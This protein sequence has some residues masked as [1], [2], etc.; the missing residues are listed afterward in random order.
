MLH[1]STN[2]IVQRVEEKRKQLAKL[3]PWPKTYLKRLH[4]DTLENWVTGNIGLAFSNFKKKHLKDNL[5]LANHNNI[6]ALIQ[7]QQSIAEK[8]ITQEIKAVEELLK[9]IYPQAL[10]NK[11]NLLLLPT[12]MQYHNNALV[13]IAHQ[14]VTVNDLVP[15]NAQAQIAARAL[16]NLQLWQQGYGYILYN[17]ND[18]LKW[19]Q[20]IN[21]AQ[22][23]NYN[24]LVKLICQ[25]VEIVL[26]KMH[27]YFGATVAET[28]TITNLIEMHNLPYSQEYLSLLI[29]QG[30]IAASKNGRNWVTTKKAIAEY[31]KNRSRVR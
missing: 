7:Q 27:T 15:A 26:D 2:K 22:E 10:K 9:L 20:A 18:K 21:K 6:N 8:I 13:N 19:Q 28:D 23:N 14:M 12:L 1:V 4:Y 17:S 31:F 11:S 5:F 25:H 24:S 29:R 3:Q 30:K 16:I